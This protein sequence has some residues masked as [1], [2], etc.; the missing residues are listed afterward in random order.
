MLVRPEYLIQIIDQ[1]LEDEP[2]KTG[3]NNQ[4][5]LLSETLLHYLEHL[6]Y[7]GRTLA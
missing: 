4:L 6:V 3:K 2:L 5:L 1:R 7:F